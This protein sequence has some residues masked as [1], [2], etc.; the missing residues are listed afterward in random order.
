MAKVHEITVWARGVLQD[1]EGRDVIN[2]FAAALQ[3]EGKFSQAFDNY[4]DLPDRVLVPLRK[5]V[6]FSDEEIEHKYVYTND[7]P[8]IVVILEQTIVKGINILKG[9]QKGGILIVNTS[10]SADDILGFIPNNDLLGGIGTLD[11]TSI[12]GSCTIDFSGSE[13]GIDATHL[14]AGLA[15]PM[16]GAMARVTELVKKETLATIVKDVAGMEKGYSE[17]K[18]MKLKNYVTNTGQLGG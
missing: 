17:V 6:R 5:Y 16:V 2:A 3:K 13:G 4:E 15:A 7:V 10:K 9:M 11:A 14:C 18:F 8:E 1:K 12:S